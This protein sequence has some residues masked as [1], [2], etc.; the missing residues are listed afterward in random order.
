MTIRIID[1]L[2]TVNGATVNTEEVKLKEIPKSNNFL[3]KWSFGYQIP[4]PS[5]PISNAHKIIIK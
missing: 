2:V 4:L 3:L 1:V 5:S